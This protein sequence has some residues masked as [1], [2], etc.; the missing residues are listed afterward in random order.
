MRAYQVSRIYQVLWA[1]SIVSSTWA[2]G[3]ITTTTQQPPPIPEILTTGL[4]EVNQRRS[5]IQGSSHQIDRLWEE[6]GGV[7][8]M[9]A[10]IA[11]QLDKFNNLYLG[12]LEHRMLTTSTLLASIDSNI[13][14][15]QERSHAW[16]TFQLHVAAWNEQIKSLDNK[17]D[18][19]SRGQEK[20]VVLDTKVSQL[21]NLEYKL[22][23]ITSRLEET[24]QRIQQLESPRDPL[25][26]E[27]ATRGVLSTLKIVERKVDRVQTGI[28]SIGTNLKSR[29]KKNETEEA[30][31][32]LVIRCNTPPAVE[33]ALQDVQAKVDLVYDKLVS[34]PESNELHD[35]PDTSDLPRTE[36]KLLNKLWKRLLAPQRK[37][38]KSLETIESLVRGMNNTN[39]CHNGDSDD[40]LDHDIQELLSC[41]RA[42]SHRVN[43]FAENAET[44][45]KRVEGVVNQVHGETSSGQN[46]L[47]RRFSE[48]KIHLEHLLAKIGCV[49]PQANG[50][51]RPTNTFP[52]V[53]YDGSGDTTDDA[54]SGDDEDAPEGSADGEVT[55][56]PL[57]GG[58]LG[59]SKDEDGSVSSSTVST[60]TFAAVY[61]IPKNHAFDNL[62][63]VTTLRPPSTTDVVTLLTPRSVEEI[64]EV[65]E[66][67]CESLEKSGRPSGVFKLGH[68]RDINAAGRDFYTRNCDLQTSGGG[69]TIVQQ[70]GGVWG[71]VENFTKSWE[72]YSQG[73]GNLNKEFWFG[74][75]YIHRLT[76]E[77]DVVLRVELEDWNGVTAWAEYSTFRVDAEGDDYRIWISGYE[78]NATDAFGAHDGTPFSTV[79]RD[80]DGAPPC[81]PCAPAYGGGWWFYSC[82]EANLNGD[83][84]QENGPHEPFRGVIWEHWRGD[85][86]LKTSRMLVRPRTLGDILVDPPDQVYPDP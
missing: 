11:G 4:P 42:S 30:S 49:H 84:I 79:D 48:Q 58:I 54:G 60:T 81:C 50:G 61:P 2:V 65:D 85:Y 67:N 31:G 26:G 18:H 75:E 52:V 41:C 22:E 16:D 83:Y 24:S 3:P 10:T 82:F 5:E 47:E 35:Q 59:R 12:K 9:M 57:G 29:K 1:I 6:I 8:T 43:S 32:K 74:N 51:S 66:R 62:P 28:H 7:K 69:W 70:R 19:L 55:V 20:M 78:G 53:D 72:E 45:M 14:G 21:M 36:A 23:R 15:L 27:F 39:S 77:T 40:D 37:M 46:A 68:T 13:H 71:G 44:I 34:E 56:I 38:T 80:N 25:M 76:Y 86:S 33:E 73:F 64:V 63:N 17:M